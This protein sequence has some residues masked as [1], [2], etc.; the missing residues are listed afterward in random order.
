MREFR[1]P[2]AWGLC[3]LLI[4]FA[5]TPAFSDVFDDLEVGE[6]AQDFTLRD[7]A[8]AE[9][10]LSDSEGDI[11]VIQF[12]SSTSVPFL[13]QIKPINGLVRNYRREGVTFIT[14]YTAEQMFEWQAADY[15]Q[16]Y[17]RAKGLRFQFGVQSGQRMTP[18]ILVDDTDDSVYK[19]YG[20]VPSGVFIFV[21]DED[22]SR[23]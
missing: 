16:K 10:T 13:E 22:T 4:A 3:L 21:H 11:V 1:L 20:S 9:Y 6:A 17:E 5:S 18:K 12:G 8:E 14:V 15:F 23:D 7:L 2:P 19:M